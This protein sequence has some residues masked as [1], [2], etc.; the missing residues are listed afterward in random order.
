MARKLDQIIVLDVEATCWEGDPPAGQENEIIEVGFCLLN[1]TTLERTEKT[2]FLVRPEKSKVSE[3]CTKLTT[4]TQARVDTG[5]T[6]QEVCSLL[7]KRYDAK[8][9]LWASY[10]DYDRKQFERQCAARGVGFP[11]GNSHLNVKTLFAIVHALPQEIGMAE[12]LEKLGLP[13]EGTHHRGHDDAWNIAKIL[14]HL[15]SQSRGHQPAKREASPD[16]ALE[17]V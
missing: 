15:L 13:L 16:P 12:A 1:L 2:S 3:F 6:F 11:F 17:G 14:A 8:D 4:L 5:K 10:G 7:K 9:R